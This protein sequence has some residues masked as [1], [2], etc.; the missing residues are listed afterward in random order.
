MKTPLQILALRH[1]HALVIALAFIALVSVLMI[2]WFHT[3]AHALRSA[4]AFDHSVAAE[5]LADVAVNVVKGQIGDGTRTMKKGTAS[6][7][8][9]TTLVWTSQPG[10]IRTYGT[11]GLPYRFY[12]LYSSDKMVLTE[13]A[14]RH[15]SPEEN[16]AREV[17]DDWHAQPALFTD[18]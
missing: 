4:K 6:D 18:L 3:T 11:D 13:F 12:K 15:W 5:R 17:P 2:M 16:A 7:D 14:G 10:L 8:P 1:G 9:A